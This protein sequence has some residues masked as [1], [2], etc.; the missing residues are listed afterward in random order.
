MRSPYAVTNGW[1]RNERGF[2]HLEAGTLLPVLQTCLSRR[3]FCLYL[4]SFVINHGA[5]PA[6]ADQATAL[7]GHPECPLPA[8]LST[9]AVEHSLEKSWARNAAGARRLHLQCLAPSLTGSGHGARKS[10][11]RAADVLR[12]LRSPNWRRGGR[13]KVTASA[14]EAS[15]RLHPWLP[16]LIPEIG[17]LNILLGHGG[18]VLDEWPRQALERKPS[19][20][21]TVIITRPITL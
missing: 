21:L 5:Q 11:I 10:G 2:I 8:R 7:A 20:T 19:M 6:P 4:S 18:R 12:G 14:F 13:L 17:G 16:P 15:E 9:A 1:S 3:L